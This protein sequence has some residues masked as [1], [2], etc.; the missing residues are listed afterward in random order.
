MSKKRGGAL[1]YISLVIPG[2]Q[3][4]EFYTT[5]IVPSNVVQNSAPG[6]CTHASMNPH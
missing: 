6:V 3:S 4:A 5:N 1:H 2:E